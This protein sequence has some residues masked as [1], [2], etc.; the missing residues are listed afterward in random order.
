MVLILGGGVSGITAAITLLE[1][2]I[3]KI[4]VVEARE[5]LGG[6]LRSA[7]FCGHTIEVR[8]PGAWIARPALTLLPCSSVQIGSMGLAVGQVKAMRTPSEPCQ[9]TRY[10]TERMFLR[11][12]R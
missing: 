10:Y 3:K 8:C 7:T 6:W 5:E 1:K 12:H 9:S 4:T 11:H 2:G